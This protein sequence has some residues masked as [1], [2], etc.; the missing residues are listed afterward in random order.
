L[1]KPRNKASVNVSTAFNCQIL[2]DINEI[3]GDKTS[4]C[5]EELRKR[6]SM[7]AS[8]L[9]IMWDDTAFPNIEYTGGHVIGA[10]SE[11]VPSSS[12]ALQ[13]LNH[14]WPMKSAARRAIDVAHFINSIIKHPDVVSFK[15][16]ELM[17][18]LQTGTLPQSNGI[19]SESPDDSEG[20]IFT[21]CHDPPFTL[22]RNPIYCRK[23]ALRL[24]LEMEA[25][26]IEFV[27]GCPSFVI[28]AH[29]Y[30]ATNQARYLK[31]KWR[32]MD[33][34]I[35]AHIDQL[36]RGN[37]PTTQHDILTRYVSKV[38]MPLKGFIKNGRSLLQHDLLEAAAR[39]NSIM[40][41]S[42]HSKHLEDYISGADSAER[43]LYNLCPPDRKG[44]SA[45]KPP[46][47]YLEMIKQ[48]VEKLPS[49]LRKIETDYITL[50]KLSNKLFDL[51]YAK[52]SSEEHKEMEKRFHLPLMS[53]PMLLGMLLFCDYR[54]MANRGSN[55][56]WGVD[57]V[58]TRFCTAANILN[59]FLDEANQVVDAE[60]FDV[61]KETRNE[62]HVRRLGG[63]NS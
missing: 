36:F 3:L 15:Q 13:D 51:I 42:E 55:Y 48:G 30:N 49:V 24:Q 45:R 56:Q 57:H 2:L 20:Q 59:K 34:A 19:S 40:K 4:T 52:L 50:N 62:E 7:A 14:I 27:N 33:L 22:N 44:A 32:A 63:T 38:G 17:K 35:A 37:L 6:G 47:T 61:V 46:P 39:V 25:L 31:G 41:R 9:D 8:I 23:K 28:A 60:P 29:L 43:L 58:G 10:L 5:Y 16:C 11:L 18:H 26:G 53:K 21:P 1:K 12:L 54:S